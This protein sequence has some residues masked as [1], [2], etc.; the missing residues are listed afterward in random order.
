MFLPVTVITF[1]ISRTSEQCP[2]QLGS[3][4]AI[5]F[6]SV[7]SCRDFS[8]WFLCG[9][10]ILND[11]RLRQSFVRSSQ[12]INRESPG[13]IQF[14]S[15]WV[16]PMQCIIWRLVNFPTGARLRRP[17]DRSTQSVEGA[18]PKQL[19]PINSLFRIKGTEVFHKMK[20]GCKPLHFTSGKE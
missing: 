15:I 2:V 19:R 11:G 20:R 18:G 1:T 16:C 8:G 13:H 10:R 9:R 6:L 5:P 7:Y 3:A 12:R 14:M 4:S 17:A